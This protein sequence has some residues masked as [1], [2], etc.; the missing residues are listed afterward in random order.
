MI[1]N[2]PEI[3]G[4][5]G[6]RGLYPENTLAAIRAGIDLSCDA[7]EVDLCV[8]ADNQLVIHHDPVLSSRLV[9]NKTGKWIK[10]RLKVRSL[11]LA[12]LKEFDVGRIN[13]KS[14]YAGLYPEQTPV[15]GARIPILEEFVDLVTSVQSNITYNLELKSTPDSPKITPQ[16]EEYVKLVVEALNYHD[17]VSR[18]FLQSFDWRLVMHAKSLLPNLKIGMLTNQQTDGVPLSPVPGNPNLWTSE[19][20]L[21]NFDNLPAMVKHAGGDV[22]SCNALDI[23]R[24]EIVTAHQLGLEVYVWTVN[25]QTQMHKMIEYGVDAITTDYPDRLSAILNKR[26]PT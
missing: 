1:R 4:H 11:T 20:D 19:F 6:A 26:Q 21:N 12:E 14:D 18:T 25:C 8:S 3:H 22:W 5:R 10:N 7:I 16:V 24:E 23:S 15:D 9:R 2:L 13:P 17:I